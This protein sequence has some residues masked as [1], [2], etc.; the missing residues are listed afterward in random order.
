M[1]YSDYS[2]RYRRRQAE[3]SNAESR[4]VVQ[5]AACRQPRVDIANVAQGRLGA[6]DVEATHFR[7]ETVERVAADA[8]GTLASKDNFVIETFQPV[9]ILKRRGVK[10]R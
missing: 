10:I 8:V 6:E 4:G 3:T 7:S 2:P 9:S 1:V 5:R